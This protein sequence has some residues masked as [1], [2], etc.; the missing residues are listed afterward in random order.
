[1][2]SPPALIILALACAAT[3]FF[4]AN[5]W[6]KIIAMPLGGSFFYV[7]AKRDGHA[8]GY[9][10]GYEAGHIEAIHKTLGIRPEEAAEMRDF[11]TQMEIDDM[12]VQKMNER[13]KVD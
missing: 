9:I 1:M 10:D 3:Y 12:V 5:R 4:V 11:A 7:L 13:N 6:V 2:G 8:A